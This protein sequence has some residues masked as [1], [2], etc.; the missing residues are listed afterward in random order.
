ML[1]LPFLHELKSLNTEK[2]ADPF[3]LFRTKS[4]E[5]LFEAKKHPLRYIPLKGLYESTFK[6]TTHSLLDKSTFIEA[7]L[8]E[9]LHSHLV[10]VDGH[11]SALL[12]DVTALPLLI[13]PLEEAMRTHS[14]FLQGQFSKSSKEESDPFAHLNL[15]L[16][17][18]GVF[19]YLPPKNVCSAPLQCLYLSTNEHPVV[20]APRLHL[21]L[22]LLSQMQCIVT[23]RSLTES[24]HFTLPAT[25]LF[26]EEG[27]SL[28]LFQTLDTLPTWHFETVRATVKKNAKLNIVNLTLGGKAVRQSYQVQLKGENSEATLSGL[29]LL[30]KNRIHHIHAVIDHE[31]PHTRS[32]QKFKNVLKD[33][34][35]AYFEGKILVRPEA[36]KTE[37]Y[38]LNN[39][40]L[41]S[42]GA[43]ARTKPSLEIFAD[44]VKASHGATISQLDDKQ[45]LYLKTRG[46]DAA[47]AA[48]LL[49]R[50]FCREILEKIPYALLLKNFDGRDS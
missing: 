39:N 36:Q 40:L 23:T 46:I 27:A 18:E 22:G 19:A 6:K 21:V 43:I 44:D 4:W 13:V 12:S 15:A 41:L 2:S 10:F 35:Q 42:Q 48:T 24:V 29:A 50:G 11:F 9:C 38:Q 28:D 14:G 30:Q 3:R 7:I 8:P 34:S 31:A 1:D 33:H 47:S 20:S 45:L 25:E 49:T 16:H 26:L 5:R 37:G 32:L 17:N